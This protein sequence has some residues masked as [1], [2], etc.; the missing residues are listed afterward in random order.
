[1]NCD[2]NQKLS[3]FHD[4]ELPPAER[5]HME[6]H[7]LACA[8]C[9]AELGRLQRTAKFLQAAVMPGMSGSALSRMRERLGAERMDLING[10]RTARLAGWLTAAAAAVILSCGAALYSMQVEPARNTTQVA[11][12]KAS[13]DDTN[14]V[15]LNAVVPGSELAT[16][17]ESSD[18]LTLAVSR[19]DLLRDD[20][21]E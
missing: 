5:T 13:I 19:D 10:L 21:R 7:L 11:S 14:S 8:E 3:A 20:G 2:W 9:S 6:A 12:A 15:L 4:G 16:A 1:M 18:P 17:S